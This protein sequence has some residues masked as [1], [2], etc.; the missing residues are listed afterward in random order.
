MWT[1]ILFNLLSRVRSDFISVIHPPQFWSILLCRGCLCHIAECS[2]EVFAG[3]KLVDRE[4]NR[5]S[6]NSQDEYDSK[7]KYITASIMSSLV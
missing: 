4:A 3:T 1:V 6:D 5:R 7:G 2:N